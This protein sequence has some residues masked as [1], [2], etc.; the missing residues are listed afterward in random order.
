MPS[1]RSLFLPALAGLALST[2]CNGGSGGT[3]TE[4]GTESQTYEPGCIEVSDQDFAYAHFNDALLN[5]NEG[6]T[7]TLCDDLSQEL[8]ITSTVTIDAA[9]FTLRPPVNT[10]ALT[11]GD[12]GDVTLIN[13]AVES[14]R[15]AFVVEEGGSLIVRDAALLEVPNYGVDVQS[16]ATAVLERV[17][18]SSPLWGGARVNGGTLTMRDSTIDRP[19]AYGVYV[20]RDGTATV[21]NTEIIGVTRRETEPANLFDIDGVGVWLESGSSATLVGNRIVDPEI[22]GVNADDSASITLD[23]N[24][25]RGGF[26]GITIR[27]TTL[28]VTDSEI[29][30]YFAYGLLCLNCRDAELHSTKIETSPETSRVTSVNS[31]G[32]QIDGSI[33]VFG[34]ES[35]IKLTGTEESPSTMVG[36]NYAG[37]LMSPTGGGTRADLEVQDTIIDNNAAFGIGVFSG[38]LTM[39]R[40]QVL[41]TRSDDDTCVTST[42]N[43]CNMAIALF[44]SNATLIDST[45]AES[46]DWGLTVVNGVV[47]VRG[48]TFAANNFVS[49][50][51]Q[52]SSFIAEDSLWTGNTN[53][54]VYLVSNA[55][56]VLDRA[57]FEE[58]RYGFPI[59]RGEDSFDIYRFNG[60]STL[61]SGSELTIT[62]S[63]FDG[64]DYGPYA[65]NGSIT[66]RD[67]TFNNFNEN[68]LRALNSGSIDAENITMTNIGRHALSCATNAEIRVDN[69]TFSGFTHAAYQVDTFV[70]GELTDT[71]S[72]DQIG[73][74]VLANNCNLRLDDVTISDTTNSAID[75]LN[76]QVLFGNISLSNVSQDRN[77]T[78]GGGA[79]QLR[80]TSSEPTAVLN[81]TSISGV[82]VGSALFAT[83]TLSLGGEITVNHLNIGGEGDEDG[84][85]GHGVDARNVADLRI[86]GLDIQHVGAR[87]LSL[88]STRA[89]VTGVSLRRSGTIQ[90][91]GGEGVYATAIS[92]DPEA[93]V[94]LAELTILNTGADGI[95]V[96]GGRHNMT[97]VSVS[98][99]LG[100]GAVCEA[101]ADFDVCD[102]ALDGSDGPSMGCVCLGT[103]D[104]G[105]DDDDDDDDDDGSDGEE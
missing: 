85:A 57:T 13:V 21:E 14:T 38:E 99:A 20:E 10:S 89:D 45:V 37:A 93:G 31:A 75:T 23:G 74:A 81:S 69:G 59:E 34:L 29:L 17:E 54:G 97:E 96:S 63:T 61:V 71:F 43:A 44:G 41:R 91:T 40:S 30:D 5:A 39:E 83:S 100:F 73:P 55:T 24:E 56:G 95:V 82:G 94:S 86:S 8:I 4:T 22:V 87:G 52:Q 88:T 104:L 32:D 46:A 51:A 28:N 92:D 18:M 66:V 7:I 98:D 25:I 60:Y 36:N 68:V 105:D 9:G 64:G 11:V 58:Q 15:S 70:G 101:G 1:I 33:G 42:G 16:G 77:T 35:S 48:S 65:T 62:N 12:G 2:A 80:Y 6:D 47:D 90:N 78:T 26:A 79:L 49:V 19:G 84:I 67:T 53:Y 72:F 3:D 76:S 102:A 27:N 50:F 103:G